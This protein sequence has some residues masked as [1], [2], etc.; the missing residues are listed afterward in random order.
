[1]VAISEPT[2]TLETIDLA[3][4]EASDPSERQKLVQAC[5]DQGFLYLNLASNPQLVE[6]WARVLDFMMQYFA[7]GT[8]EKMQDNRGSDTYGY[9]DHSISN[10]RLICLLSRLRYE[11]VATSTGAVEGL[12]D[13]YESLKVKCKLIPIPNTRPLMDDRHLM[14][15]F[16][17]TML[18]S[19]L[20]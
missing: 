17:G 9:V 11:P 1:M 2:F 12:P 19:P 8:V 18:R 15:A 3:L 6:D 7:Q 4:L 5:K 16:V 13:Y 20:P 10:P 14:M